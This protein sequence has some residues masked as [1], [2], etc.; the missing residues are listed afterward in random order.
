MYMKNQI[1]LFFNLTFLALI[2][3]LAHTSFSPLAEHSVLY[4]LHQEAL[5]RP[6]ISEYSPS[7][8]EF[9]EKGYLIHTGEFARGIEE[10]QKKPSEVC[11]KVSSERPSL[12]W[13][14]NHLIP[15]E[16]FWGH[17]TA[18][19]RLKNIWPQ[20]VSVGFNE[21]MTMGDYTL[22]KG[23]ILIL[24][25]DMISYQG[26]AL[27]V[28]LSASSQN[29]LSK[30]ELESLFSEI[31]IDFCLVR[32]SLKAT[33]GM[34]NANQNLSQIVEE[35]LKKKNG[36]VVSFPEGRDKESWH[37]TQEFLVDGLSILNDVFFD[38]LLNHQPKLRVGHS[39]FSFLGYQG[40]FR[41]FEELCLL[42]DR[43]IGS[44][45]MVKKEKDG[46]SSVVPSFTP[47][48]PYG[49][50]YFMRF[51]PLYPD[52]YRSLLRTYETMLPVSL[53]E[54]NI[55][56]EHSAYLFEKIRK[57]RSFIELVIPQSGFDVFFKS[58]I[59]SVESEHQSK[60]DF[61]TLS[62]DRFFFKS[63]EE[64]VL[65]M[66]KLYISASNHGVQ[67]GF[68]VDQLD[69]GWD[70]FLV[71]VLRN[72]PKPIFDELKKTWK[73]WQ[74]LGREKRRLITSYFYLLEE[75]KRRSPLWTYETESV[76][77]NRS[78]L[79]VL[80]DLPHNMKIGLYFEIFYHNLSYQEDFGFQDMEKARIIQ[81]CIEDHIT[82][83]IR[84]QEELHRQLS[85]VPWRSPL[86]ST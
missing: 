16:G 85:I 8:E 83:F 29:H 48:E 3:S 33:E 25:P 79:Q 58:F 1:Y 56:Q 69:Q 9:M 73:G 42:S 63:H 17:G 30:E 18:L 59:S 77:L 38:A 23:D 67:Y 22:K 2:P 51:L 52:F 57:S 28:N 10:G 70:Y 40:N 35:L 27:G 81:D 49:W 50:N 45:L 55:S 13:T 72:I 26:S 31:G 66:K 11:I 86:S 80:Q 60:H 7:F 64:F 75:L 41:L 46:S 24:S 5:N 4:E 44:H 19:V 74:R 21:V 68:L 71:D 82:S 76:P 78:D 65:Y 62:D 32:G 43:I 61:M 34:K 36:W 53:A 54:L 12:F 47:G 15:L 37:L 6:F 39:T 84:G 20:L 14:L